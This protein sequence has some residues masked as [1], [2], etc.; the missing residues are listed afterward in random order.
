[1][2]E[3]NS[4][5]KIDYSKIAKI[6]RVLTFVLSG[7]L[8]ALV[9]AG[10]F[11]E[12]ATQFLNPALCGAIAAA[13][14][15]FSLELIEIK[16]N[17]E[18]TDQCVEQIKD[19][20]VSN[21]LDT[22]YLYDRD[23]IKKLQIRTDGNIFTNAKSI[24]MSGMSLRGMAISNFESFQAMLQNG[25]S[26]TFALVAP[27]G[28]A[29]AIISKIYDGSNAVEKYRNEIRGSLAYFQKLKKEFPKQVRIIVTDH[30]PSTSITIIDRNEESAECFVEIYTYSMKNVSDK[31]LKTMTR[32]HLYFNRKN[33]Q[34]W[35]DYFF[36][37]FNEIIRQG[38]EYGECE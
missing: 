18:K 15:S 25:G 27:D 35:M 34:I 31:K 2:I 10:F 22:D 13:I 6:L 14:L 4:T 7:S 26:C 36:A 17:C 8:L 21:T 24:E 28:K 11:K 20:L 37:Q 33:S 30:I 1:M 38:E 23:A 32:P 16:N 9:G 5:K 29:P 19:S 12:Q 3:L